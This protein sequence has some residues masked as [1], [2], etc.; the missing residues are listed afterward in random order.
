MSVSAQSLM[1]V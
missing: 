1:R